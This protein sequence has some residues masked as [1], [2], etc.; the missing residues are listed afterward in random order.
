MPGDAS[1][2][3]PGDPVIPAQRPAWRGRLHTWAFA[4]GIPAAVLLVLVADQL[5]ARI[6]VV[7]YGTSLAAVFGTSAAYHRLARSPTAVRRLRRLDHAMI[8]V[9]IAGT[10]TPLCLLSL[11]PAWGIPLLVV[12][13][14]G[15]AAGIVLKLVGFDRFVRIANGLYLVLGWAVVVAVPVLVTRLSPAGLALMAFGGLAY[16]VGAVVLFRRRPDPAPAVFGFH[17]V[18]HACTLVAAASHY[19]LVWLLVTG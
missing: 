7:V 9:L 11:P 8:Y 12:A 1:G 10:Y 15:A 3:A 5:S 6:A 19:G 14:T 18:W 4:A 16:T 17:E 2:D 13:W